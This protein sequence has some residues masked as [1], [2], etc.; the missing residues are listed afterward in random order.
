MLYLFGLWVDLTL[1]H[2]CYWTEAKVSY[3]SGAWTW[4]CRM[5]AEHPFMP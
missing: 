4:E 3:L 2:H 1:W 5:L